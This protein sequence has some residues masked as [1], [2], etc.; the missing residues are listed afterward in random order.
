MTVVELKL[1]KL[2]FLETNNYL[3]VRIL[4]T[5]YDLFPMHTHVFYSV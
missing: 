4:N 3:K 1:L 5:L 2:F